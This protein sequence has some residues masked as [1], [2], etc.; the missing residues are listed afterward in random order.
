[1]EHRYILHLLVAPG[2][3]IILLVGAL[4]VENQQNGIC[5]VPSLLHADFVGLGHRGHPLI[6]TKNNDL[7]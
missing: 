5:D 2:L 3:T 4:R 7:V 1:M 6:K